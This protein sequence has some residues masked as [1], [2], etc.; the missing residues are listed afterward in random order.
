MYVYISKWSCM[1]ENYRFITS[2]AYFLENNTLCTH[3]HITHA[4]CTLR[5]TDTPK[6][7]RINRNRC[8]DFNAYNCLQIEYMCTALVSWNFHA[9]LF[10]FGFS[11]SSSFCFVL[12]CFYFSAFLFYFSN[13]TLLLFYF[14]S[15]HP[16]CTECGILVFRSV[17][18]HVMLHTTFDT[19]ILA[20]IHQML[21]FFRCFVQFVLSAAVWLS[22]VFFSL[23]SSFVR[24]F[25]GEYYFIAH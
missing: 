21:F 19:Y 22:C 2:S 10:L 6:N 20:L 9:V 13:R 4:H 15:F 24:L 1:T 23:C 14:S 25:I 16:M 11:S 12:H 8:R 3:V 17:S 18:L 7:H 5:Y